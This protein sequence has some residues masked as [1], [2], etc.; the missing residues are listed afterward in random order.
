ML[1]WP[2]WSPGEVKAVAREARGGLCGRAR[3]SARSNI[4]E[5]IYNLPRLEGRL[6]VLNMPC[7]IP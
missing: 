3:E 6:A 2:S 7:R 5:P 4:K 1:R